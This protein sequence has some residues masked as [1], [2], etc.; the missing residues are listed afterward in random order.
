MIDA[1]DISNAM[2]RLSAAYPG[3]PFEDGWTEL[4][5]D[6]VRDWESEDLRDAV[7]TVIR[8][9]KYRPSIAQIVEAAG[10]AKRKSTKTWA[11]NAAGGP[12]E[13][14]ERIGRASENAA[15]PD[16]PRAYFADLMR[17]MTYREFE[18]AKAA[19]DDERMIR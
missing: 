17:R 13:R 19:A 6:V 3:R 8:S 9:S 14:C 15:L 11:Q 7:E 2:R 10:G 12:R 1:H 16:E 18:W 5:A 4:L